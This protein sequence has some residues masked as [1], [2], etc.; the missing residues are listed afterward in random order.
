MVFSI[1]EIGRAYWMN[2]G[3]RKRPTTGSVSSNRFDRVSTR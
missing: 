2:T 1:A 3:Y